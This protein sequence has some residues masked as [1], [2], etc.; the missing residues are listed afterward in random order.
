[1][2]RRGPTL[3][4][5]NAMAIDPLTDVR[6]ITKLP[7]S[8]TDAQPLEVVRAEAEKTRA[9]AAAAVDRASQLPGVSLTGTLGQQRWYWRPMQVAPSSGLARVRA[10][11]IHQSGHR[12]S[13]P[14]RVRSQREFRSAPCVVLKSR[15]SAKTRQS[16]E[17]AGLTQQA[18]QNLDLFQEQYKAG[19]R[20]VM[21]VVGV[22][23][24]FARAANH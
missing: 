6:G 3:S 14:Q 8:A 13:W 9:I 21:D 15:I 11:T 22:Y 19:Q 7:V 16:H 20:Q 12:N 4:E 2:K 5:L 18:K 10:L 23:E 1:M 17:A 24:T